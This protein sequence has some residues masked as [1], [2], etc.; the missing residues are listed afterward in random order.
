MIARNPPG[1]HVQRVAGELE[2]DLPSAMS[3]QC[4]LPRGWAVPP[5]LSPATAP[6]FLPHLRP[7]AR[8][9]RLRICVCRIQQI[10]FNWASCDAGHVPDNFYASKT[11]AAG[12]RCFVVSPANDQ[13]VPPSSAYRTNPTISREDTGI[14]V[15]AAAPCSGWFSK[16]LRCFLPVFR[17][18]S[19]QPSAPARYVDQCRESQGA[20][21]LFHTSMKYEVRLSKPLDD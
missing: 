18:I 1:Y 14:L 11:S 12:S 2:H 6:F 4:R 5:N 7:A 8:N 16:Y 3:T 10:V 21:L 17:G 19:T 15:S 13:A 20:R 9:K